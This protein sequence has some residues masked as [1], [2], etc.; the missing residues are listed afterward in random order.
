MIGQILRNHGPLSRRSACWCCGV[1]RGQVSTDKQICGL[2]PGVGLRRAGAEVFSMLA[3]ATRART[4]LALRDAGEMSVNHL[5]DVVDK[6][7]PRAVG[8]VSRLIESELTR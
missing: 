8:H 5:A 2:D 6:A 3:D 4:I 7:R 1:V